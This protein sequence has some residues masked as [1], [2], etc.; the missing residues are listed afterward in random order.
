MARSDLL[1]QL[2]LTG[3]EGDASRFRRVVEAVVSEERAKQHHV[4]AEQLEG[5]LKK[6]SAGRTN[7]QATLLS[8]RA[9]GIDDLLHEV[10]PRR[11]LG[12]LVLPDGVREAC[13]ELAEEHARSDLLRSYALEP[14]HRVM[15]TGPPGNGK[16]SLAE[17]VAGLLM[18]PLLVLRYDGVVGSFLGETA[19]RLR[20]VFDHVRARPCVLFLDE[21]DTIGKERGDT[22]ETGEIK[23]VVSSLL[24]GVD[25]LPSYVVLVTAT[26]HPELLDRAVWRRFQV[27]IDLPSPSRVQ[28]EH[29][30]KLAEDRLGF[31]FEYSPRRLADVLHGASFAELEEFALDVARRRVLLMPGAEV[32]AIVGERLKRWRVRGTR[33]SRKRRRDTSS[34]G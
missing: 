23:R 11:Q 28:V 31:G 9:S 19:Q 3:M 15:L 24:L 26:N 2:V 16:T 10:M 14:R 29:W 30:V 1:N 20:R 4:L 34:N 17:A 22:H 7:G 12:E 13:E 21:F 18:V 5:H 6:A 33:P 25:A 27:R 8:A 32:R